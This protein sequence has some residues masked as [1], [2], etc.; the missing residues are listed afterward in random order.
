MVSFVFVCV[1]L[2]PSLCASHAFPPSVPPSLPGSDSGEPISS[3]SCLLFATVNS[4]LQENGLLS[5][6]RA[7]SFGQVGSFALTLELRGGGWGGAA[8]EEGAMLHCDKRLQESHVC[9][10][11]LV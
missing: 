9:S 7:F 3:R 6:S 1:S 2:P 5:S 11:V 8:C 4:A 10:V